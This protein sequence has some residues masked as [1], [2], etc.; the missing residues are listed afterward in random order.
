MG[1]KT[2]CAAVNSEKKKKNNGTQVPHFDYLVASAMLAK[3]KW[4][5][6]LNSVSLSW[7]IAS[8]CVSPRSLIDRLYQAKASLS[9][10]PKPCVLWGQRECVSLPFTCTQNTIK[11]NLMSSVTRTRFPR[12]PLLNKRAPP[13]T[14]PTQWDQTMTKLRGSPT[15][16]C[17]L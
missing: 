2:S 5:A 15:N 1:I 3:V 13:W 9:G 16:F 12:W 6:F 7:F 17:R 11:N 4:W 8:D 10:F 14:E